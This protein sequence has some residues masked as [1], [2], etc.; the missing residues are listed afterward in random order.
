MPY[1]RF[2][3]L[4]DKNK[5]LEKQI[6]ELKSKPTKTLEWEDQEVYDEMKNKFW[7]VDRQEASINAL[8]MEQK[9]V[10]EEQSK[11]IEKQISTMEKEFDGSDGLPKFE[12]K[13]IIERGIENNI[14][15][16]KSAYIMKNLTTII[17]HFVNEEVS[18]RRTPMKA[19]PQ[20]PEFKEEKIDTSK[21]STKD[22]SLTDFL[23]KRLKGL[24]S[25]R[26]M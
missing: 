4:N 23:T 22:W 16:P 21:L 8:E 3:E 13:D 25:A 17:N 12:K 20:E 26:G 10:L 14:Y 19:K 1:S 24:A 18:K 15:D 2:K 6:E 11:L 9:K 5:A 7:F